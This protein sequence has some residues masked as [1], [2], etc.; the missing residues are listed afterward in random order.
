MRITKSNINKF[1]KF[2]GESES[3]ITNTYHCLYFSMLLNK[4]SILDFSFS[5]KFNNLKYDFIKRGEDIRNID[6]NNYLQESIDLNNKF[7]DKLL[8]MENKL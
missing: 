5:Q 4:T 3:I 8:K 6:Y 7:Y 1:I 2:I